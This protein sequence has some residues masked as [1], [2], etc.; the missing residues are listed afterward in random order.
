MHCA[1]PDNTQSHESKLRFAPPPQERFGIPSPTRT[2]TGGTP[3]KQSAVT[4]LPP[5]ASIVRGKS[6]A[7]G[8][9][10]I[11]PRHLRE[12]VHAVPPPE[13]TDLEL[14]K[15]LLHMVNRG[16]L[17]PKVDLTPALCG[18]TGMCMCTYC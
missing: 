10:V 18:D 7:V 11:L 4:K 15:G 16:L 8:P 13:V 6:A 12:D 9:G 3:D 2:G 14:E 5:A 1:Q 17:P